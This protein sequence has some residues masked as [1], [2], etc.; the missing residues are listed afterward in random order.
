MAKDELVK[1]EQEE[2]DLSLRFTD[3]VLSKLKSSVPQAME[4]NDYQRS[5]IGGYAIAIKRA[6][7][8]AEEQ[9]V[10]KNKKN[11]D[12]KWDIDVPVTLSNV[13]REKLAVDL[14]HYAKLGLDMTQDNMLFPIP[15]Y[16]WKTRTYT[17]N[18]M[19]GY[20]G[21]KYIAEKYALHPPKAVTVEVVY[22][23]DRFEVVKKSASNPVESYKFEV[24]DPF[25]R[26]EIIGAFAYLTYDV[27]EMNELIVMSMQAI[28]KRKP[29][30]ASAQFWG[31]DVA[32]WKN[33][34]QETV[35][36]EGWLDEMVRKAMIREAYSPK[37]IL[38]DPSKID[39]NYQYIKDRESQYTE[40]VVQSEVAQNANTVEVDLPAAPIDPATTGAPSAKAIEAV[41]TG[42]IP[43]EAINAT[44][45]G[46]APAAEPAVES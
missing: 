4:V 35:H 20:N 46:S 27:P 24:T 28:M 30:Y 11:T 44:P 22:S 34:K 41:T 9:R 25:N 16:D 45:T 18:L 10:A 32:E 37:H 1:K 33:G 17:I 3:M 29:K 15:F 8:V 6:L 31:G 43:A 23:T 7:A 12:H 42:T 36:Y 21:V 26:G 40:V 13:D 19:R 38:L 39:D 5:L 14:V 2:V